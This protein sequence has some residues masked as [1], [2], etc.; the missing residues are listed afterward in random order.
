MKM[1]SDSVYVTNASTQL[2]YCLVL[3]MCEQYHAARRYAIR[4]LRRVVRFDPVTICLALTFV[5]L[6]TAGAVAQ[7]AALVA[8]AGPDQ[9][10][11]V[12][13][14][15]VQ[16]DGTGST[17]TVGS[18]TVT[19]DWE[20][21]GGT[22]DGSVTLTDA[23]T[24]QPSFTADTLDP[25]AAAV[26]HVF[27]LTV[28]DNLG[29]AQATDMV[30]ITV[31]APP[32]AVP[33]FDQ[34]VPPGWP[35]VL[36][37]V[38]SVASAGR[39]TEYFWFSVESAP[40][41]D[42]FPPHTI[43]GSKARF[44][45][46]DLAPDAED[47]TYCFFLQV[48]QSNG[49][50][51]SI[52]GPLKV[53]VTNSVRPYERPVAKIDGG[54][55]EVASGG[56]VT[57]NGIESTF[58]RRTG[59]TYHWERTGGTS[60]ATEVLTVDRRTPYRASFTAENL[61]ADAE[62]V[63]HILTLTVTDFQGGSSTATVTITV[64]AALV[65]NA[66][67]DQ[68][69]FSGMTVTLDSS[70][71][72][73]RGGRRNVTYA[74]T[75][76]G[77]TGSAVNLSDPT[78]VAPTFTPTLD[79]GDAPVTYIFTLT[80]T[81]SANETD[82]DTVTITVISE[83][84][85]PVAQA[86]DDESV[87]SGRTVTLDGSRSTVDYRRNSSKIGGVLTGL[88]PM[89]YSWART[90][91]TS[92]ATGTLTGATTATP[93][94]T[95]E[96]RDAGAPD[97]THV[98]T[99]T[100]TDRFNVTDTDTVTI[101][102]TSA[103]VAN[104]G[105]DQ[106]NV[107]SGATVQLDGSGSTASGGGKNVTYAWTRV[108]GTGSAVNLSD[109]TDVDP[110]FTAQTLNPGDASVTYIFTLT[111][112]DSANVTDID[113]VTIT[114]FAPLFAEAGP[115]KT[116]AS[117]GTV[118][119]DGSGSTETVGVRTVA[120]AW[121]R[122]GGT[123]DDTVAPSNPAALQTSFTAEVL[124]PGDASVTHIFTLTVADNQGSTQATDTVT[125]TVTALPFDALVA[126]AG[127]DQDNVGSGTQVTLDGSG[128]TP[129]GSG[130]NVTYAWTQTGGVTVTLSNTTVLDP[131]FTAQTLNPGDAD[132][133]YEF[134]LTV[135]DDK[136]SSD[137][138]D[139]VT[140]TVKA[141]PFGNLVAEAG[142]DQD[143]V[144]SGTRV[145]LDGSGST[146][147]GSGRNVTYA[148]TQ[149]GGATVTL[150]NTTVLDPTFTAQTLNPGDADVTYE[151]TLTVTDDKGSSDATDT[152]TITV[153]APPFGNLV[154]EAGPDQDNVGSGTRVTLDGSG[155]T[156][157]GSGRNVTYAWTQ[158]GGATVT[159]SKTTVLDPTFTAQT[160]NPGDADVT[161][162]FT[163]TV[164]DDKGSS[165]ATDTVTI[166]VKAPPFGNLVAEAG[167]DQDNVGSGTR[168]TLDGSGS[169]PTGS[170]RNVT[171]AWTQTGGATV[172]LSNTTVLDP[173]FTAQ[174]LNPGDADVTYE[175][176]LT[177]TDDKG[178]SDATD[179]VTITVKAPPFGNLVAEAGPDQDNVG[180]GTRVTL[181]GSGST[182][183]G[184]GRNVTY[185]WTQTGGATVTLSN[186]TVLD[187][188]FTAQT[189]N[190]GDADVTY[191]FTLTVTDDKGSSDATDTVTITV[192]APPFGNLV[193]EAGPDQDNVGSG[194][195]V[196]LD[197][198]GSTP[199]GSGR[200]VTYAWTQTGG[201]TVTL[202]N[203]TVLDPTFTA[204]TLNPGDADVTYEFTLTV[205]D[206]KGSSD[207][208]DT[209][210]ITVKAP[211]F[212][213]LVAE[214]GPDQD[215]VGSGT[216][217][218]LD[219]SGSTPTGSGRNVTYAW[220]QTGGATVTL[221]NTTVLDPTFTAQTLNPGDA[222]VTYEFTL[223][224]T[225]DKGSSDA[226][227]TVT[228]TVKAPPFGNL[229]A[230]AG[231]DQDNVGSGTRV[232]LDGSGSTPTGSGR[233]VTYAWTQTGGATV[234]LSNTT[235]LDPT[236]T[237][238][239]LNPGDADV[240]YEFTLT[241][242]DDKGSSDATDTVTITVKA[243]PFGNLV[244][245]A[246]PDQDNVGS[247]TRVTLDGSGSTPTGS[248]RN[249]TY[250][251]TQTGGATVTL[252]N[253]TVLD[254]TFTAQTLNPGD[255]DVTYEFTLTV[256]DD[257][258]SSDATDTVTITVKAPPFGNLVAEAGPDQDNVGSGTQVTLDGSGSTPTGS[259]RNV[260]Y[261]WTQTGGATVTLSNTTVLDPTFTAQTL[262]P[263][264]A[265]VTYEFTL[266][267]TDDKGSSDAT[268]TVT[269]TVK[270]PPF[271]NLVAEAGPDQDNVGSG[272]RV[273]LDGSGSTPT[274]SGRN[275]TYAWTQTGGATV[276]LRIR[277]FWIRPSRRRR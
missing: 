131:T 97:V 91:G 78:D 252:S 2:L 179:T 80:V 23:T 118:T 82:T 146:P 235:V 169:T 190:P 8:Q 125:F 34:M 110:T 157:T 167:P 209:V 277:L 175:F 38:R 270:A 147:T 43:E 122:T 99:L 56:T 274:G 113:T 165:D 106:D 230:E 15:E 216:R 197:G 261:A 181:D 101:T 226:T 170:G 242:T 224:V 240:T 136:G 174:T 81:D 268:D 62:D 156:P 39:I 150:S 185:A 21:T 86:G 128:S 87:G 109:P 138:T 40:E 11:V 132:V 28:T 143:N 96:T 42:P 107:A 178:S 238:Q 262:N 20:R 71:S 215:N 168:V 212:G 207:A 127:P 161:Y 202:S 142:P 35:V 164:T 266:T 90:G 141:P 70:G 140:I 206:D 12:S 59:G 225:D 55:R 218:T 232:T 263:G 221:S 189:L 195:R 254:P 79:P 208:T 247:G 27:T 95:V 100:V 49:G 50:K 104:A 211:P 272:T 236:F 64:I 267:V 135:T 105:P 77:G 276:T 255:A 160:L 234:T 7:T 172:T 162:E 88:P 246:G 183:T 37:G 117:G 239:T 76:A 196:T 200:N 184:S 229:V 51:S 92:T 155:S 46:E 48:E 219:G 74:W 205:T 120:Y 72:T 14:K 129:T 148:W 187:P 25:G 63:T 259:G 253:T 116:V 176:T 133:T 191:E 18:R 137:A 61:T 19:Y 217:V 103:L 154:A 231:P 251:W 24:L 45:A 9:P 199:T 6:S 245:E 58:D 36:D 124:N 244:A 204:Q 213:N 3:A 163:L 1:G 102:V 149:T 108:G 177:V 152:V 134:T 22:M 31:T 65:A 32:I 243:P 94:F 241:V 214:A 44:T 5:F 228:I 115:A 264:D 66:G 69:N 52:V 153:K 201:A 112:T 98:L 145:T 126:E 67:P 265:D 249:V 158:T 41:C 84:A 144:G 26:T 151:F 227:D 222:D 220:T 68:E 123:G 223:T 188:T 85:D 53:T 192:K 83:F 121:A 4:C 33:G 186:T 173:T 193:A 271:G 111:V 273:T 16:L 89:L 47:V 203:T 114:V 182:P 250:A 237:A 260:T 13:G 73:A 256:T 275:V 257:K 54:D 171:Y 180:S 159:L 139:T 210:T 269:I 10:T 130:R 198:S 17:V 119:L 166:T 258:G 194:T 75:R 60:T 57:L 248:G 233:N 30:T 29:S 93:S